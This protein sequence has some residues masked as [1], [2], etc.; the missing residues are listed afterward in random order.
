MG[1]P[2]GPT[3]ANIFMCFHEKTW[4]SNCPSEFKPVF[5]RRYID[6]TFILFKHPDHVPKFFAYLDSRH[7]N[8]RYSFEVEYNSSIPFLDCNVQ[9]TDSKFITSVFRKDTF[10]GLGTSFF[11]YI[12]PKF[13]SNSVKTLLFRGYTLSSNY[14]LMHME[15]EFLKRFFKSNGYP[16]Y[17][18]D[19]SIRQ[20][21]DNREKQ[22]TNCD[23][24]SFLSFKFPYFGNQSEKMKKELYS[25]LNKYFPELK[26]NLVFVNDFK[27]GSFFRFKDTLPK[28][29]R[30]G[31]IYEFSCA[32]CASRYV[33]S[34]NR[35]LYMRA[36]EHAGKSF[37]TQAILSQPP[38]S[39]IRPHSQACNSE[40]SIDQFKILDFNSDFTDLRILESLYIYNTKPVLNSTESAFPLTIL[41]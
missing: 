17:I 22:S 37:R 38:S 28:S 3:F 16:S 11:S 9:K 6:D 41:G 14:Q 26:I 29:V 23:P 39:A 19:R 31:L 7:P 36:A 21:L 12:C 24:V 27:I 25:S 5:Y 35:N 15:F 2:L 20:L 8:I 30:S 34:T 4:L 18:I 13:K 1:L 33:G 40:I 10:T 32:Q